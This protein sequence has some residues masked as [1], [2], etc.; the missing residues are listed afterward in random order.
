VGIVLIALLWGVR[1]SPE[2]GLP[3]IVNGIHEFGD[4]P[5]SRLAR[6]LLTSRGRRLCQPMAARRIRERARLEPD[7]G[8]AAVIVPEAVERMV[9]FEQRFGGLWYSILR[10]R[11]N[12]MEY[13]L[14]GDHRYPF[15]MAYGTEPAVNTEAFPSA[16][17]QATGPAKRWWLDGDRAV[18]LRL[19]SWWSRDRGTGTMMARPDRWTM[20]CFSRT[21]DGLARASG[22]HADIAGTPIADNDWCVVCARSTPGSL[23]CK[24]IGSQ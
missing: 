6:D 9:E 1:N 2:S 11:E 12:G 22:R 19:R 15:E 10:D 23:N 5:L 21:E 4:L 18:F 16:V 24:P 3:G 14:Q 17:P 8:L 13:G 7:G 20:W